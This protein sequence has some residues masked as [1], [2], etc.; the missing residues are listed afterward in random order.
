MELFFF[1]VSLLDTF[2]FKSRRNI[3]VEDMYLVTA[4]SL[5]IASKLVHTEEFRM[6]RLLEYA[7]PFKYSNEEM[8]RC[9]LEIMSLLTWKLP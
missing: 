4:T 6:D 7:K 5:L 3:K 1:A 2:L 8:W 9:E